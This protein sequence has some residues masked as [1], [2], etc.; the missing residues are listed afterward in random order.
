MADHPRR[1]MNR[2]ERANA[3][4]GRHDIIACQ[5]NPATGSNGRIHPN[6]RSITLSRAISVPDPNQ[7]A[8]PANARLACTACNFNDLVRVP[9]S[10]TPSAFG[11][12]STNAACID[13]KDPTLRAPSQLGQLYSW[14]YSQ[15]RI[16]LA[17]QPETSSRF[18][19]AGSSALRAA[20]ASRTPAHISDKPKV[21]RSNRSHGAKSQ[22]RHSTACH[23]S[24]GWKHHRSATRTAADQRAEPPGLDLVDLSHSPAS[25]GTGQEKK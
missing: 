10:Q 16:A 4:R 13:G 17:A 20:A 18:T 12:V 5:P 7:K 15:S 14:L 23:L 24:T 3:E 8:G 6:A 11:P 19:H 22:R 21:P 9:G 25:L 2:V 1:R